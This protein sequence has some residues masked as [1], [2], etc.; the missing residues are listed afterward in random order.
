MLPYLISMIRMNKVLLST[1]ML[2]LDVNYVAA[3]SVD[4]HLC[5][6]ASKCLSDIVV[7]ALESNCTVGCTGDESCRYASIRG[8][9]ASVLYLYT[10]TS[11]NNYYLDE[12][13]IY[14]PSNNLNNHES[15]GISSNAV[16]DCLAWYSCDSASIIGS[17][18]DMVTVYCDNSYSCYGAT[19]DMSNVNIFIVD[20]DSPTG[21]WYADFILSDVCYFELLYY[22]YSNSRC[23]D[24]VYEFQNVGMVYGNEQL[25]GCLCSST[26][27][28]TVILN[29]TV[30]VISFF[31]KTI[32][33]ITAS[34]KYLN[35][36]I[37]VENYN[38]NNI[39]TVDVESAKDCGAADTSTDTITTYNPTNQPSTYPSNNPTA[40]PVP[41]TPIPTFYPTVSPTDRPTT[42]PTIPTAM[43][44]DAPTN[45][46]NS[47]T[48]L[49]S[50]Q[51]TDLTQAP[52][53]LPTQMPSGDPTPM[54]QMSPTQDPSAS[55]TDRPSLV[56]SGIPTR[57]PVMTPTVEPSISL[58]F[59]NLDEIAGEREFQIICFFAGGV[60]GL[61]LLVTL[62]WFLC[63]TRKFI[64]E[65]YALPSK[66]A[67]VE[68][69]SFEKFTVILELSDIFSDLLFA[70]DLLAKYEDV[71]ILFALGWLAL[72]FTC[73]GVVS[74][75]LKS[76]MLTFVKSFLITT[77]CKMC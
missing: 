25:W 17:F 56:P 21:L 41:T 46:T 19:F 24:S 52:T 51:P 6:T 18:I 64:G 10:G 71:Q 22:D 75:V 26:N 43:P 36:E 5:D 12:A 67:F 35:G 61:V 65:S 7:C 44:S 72:L 20:V 16:I 77:L 9:Y 28:D 32:D 70:V 74:F 27:S 53:I 29:N 73:I 69:D 47:P 3:V 4:E 30:I 45:P 23:Q 62:L 63:K 50:Q 11:S 57:A 37:A 60:M 2:C 40:S 48:K 54:P 34:D 58:S 15:T 31:I 13:T 33:D 14:L 55:P 59:G 66:D 49:P 76:K 42:S 39:A 1:L 38:P 68:M 8:D